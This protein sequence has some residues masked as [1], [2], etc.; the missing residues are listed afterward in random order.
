MGL[1]NSDTQTVD[2]VLTKVGKRRMAEGSGLNI[3]S[4]ALSDD[5]ASYFLYNPDHVSGSAQYGQAIEN[6]P[7]PE[8]VTNSHNAMRFCLVTRE[9]NILFNP[10]INVPGVTTDNNF[11]RIEDSG[12]DYAIT[13]TPSLINGDGVSP[14]FS[15]KFADTTG[16]NITGGTMINNGGSTIDFP[17]SQ[18]VLKPMEYH[19]TSI[20]VSA[21][22]TETAFETLLTVSELNSGATEQDIRFLIDA[23][24]LQQPTDRIGS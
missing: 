11:L 5:Y 6:L 8:A 9:R 22:P 10:I 20:T 18:G 19:G 1:L 17:R 16:L 14:N 4:F 12:L 13:I 2:A 15:F 3:T 24:I 7:L 21:S 23:N